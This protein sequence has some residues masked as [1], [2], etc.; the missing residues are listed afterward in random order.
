MKRSPLGGV[1][2]P[3]ARVQIIPD[4]PIDFAAETPIVFGATGHVSLDHD[5]KTG[6][7][8]AQNHAD[9]F[10]PYMILIIEKQAHDAFTQVAQLVRRKIARGKNG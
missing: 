8:T 3:L 6:G 10:V 2:P 5:V 1:L 9:K 4:P 7:V